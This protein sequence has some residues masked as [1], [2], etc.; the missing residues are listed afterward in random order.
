[1]N[2]IEDVNLILRREAVYAR[3]ET[4][5]ITLT[6]TSDAAEDNT[7]EAAGAAKLEIRDIIPTL[8]SIGKGLPP[9]VQLSQGV[10]GDEVWPVSADDVEMEET[11]EVSAL[12]EQTLTFEKMSSDPHRVAAKIYISNSAIDNASFNLVEYVRKKIA[13]ATKVYLA[14]H[15]FSFEEW[16]GNQGPFVGV[17]TVAVYHNFPDVIAAELKRLTSQGFNMSDAC[18]VMDLATE[19]RLKLTPVNN[20]GGGHFVIENGLCM[21]YPYVVSRWFNTKK[22]DDG[23]LVSEYSYAVGIGV[24]NW[25]HIAQHAGGNIV[26]DGISMAERNITV[27]TVNTRWSMTDLTEKMTTTNVYP[28]FYYRILATERG[29]LADTGDAIF[30]TSDGLLLTVD[31]QGSGLLLDLADRDNSV[32]TTSDSLTFA[33]EATE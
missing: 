19:I 24:F 1:M 21:G 25:F 8:D 22:D 23:Q 7:I 14:R 15:F 30:E 5:A 16:T 6:P 13:D 33:V 27:L 28:R 9:G 31:E 18:V 29:Y 12:N 4:R 17:N 11:D 2:K 10:T 32:L 3:R 20:E 26:L